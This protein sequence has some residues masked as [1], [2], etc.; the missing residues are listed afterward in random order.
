MKYYTGVGSRKTPPEIRLLMTK[1]A[2][3]LSATHM[4]RS[5]GAIGADQAFEAGAGS[6]KKIYVASDATEAAKTVAA[7]YHPVWYRLSDFVK[8]LHGRN[9]F[10]VLG[11]DLATPSKFLVCWT[12][13]GCVS[14]ETRALRTGGTGTAISIASE[15]GVT[16]FNLAIVS[17]RERLEKWVD[18]E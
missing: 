14:H 8:K 6:N 9:A 13:D 5:G 12:P 2:K 15:N 3:K 1:I 7:K 11:D 18:K 17:H 16:V 4:L 10:Q